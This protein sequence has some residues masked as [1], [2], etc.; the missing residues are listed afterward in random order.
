MNNF[1]L[2][3]TIEHQWSGW[4][5]AYCLICHMEDKLEVCVALNCACPCHDDLWKGLDEAF[6]TIDEDFEWEP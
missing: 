2:N 3:G 1:V 5:G 4:P 6:S